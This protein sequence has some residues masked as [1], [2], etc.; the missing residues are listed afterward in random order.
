MTQ[1]IP[2]PP[3]EAVES[4]SP[5]LRHAVCVV[6]DGLLGAP[7]QE[8]R[9][10]P[11]AGAIYPYDVLVLVRAGEPALYWMDLLRRICVRLDAPAAQLAGL[12]EPARLPDASPAEA[13]IILLGRPW[14]SMRKYG[15][16]GYFYTQL[17]AGHAAASLLGTALEDGPAALRLRA[18]RSDIRTCLSPWLPHREVHSVLTIGAPHDRGEGVA[19][20]TYRLN[21]DAGL[22]HAD[23][24]ESLCWSG[25]PEVLYDNTL[26]LVEPTLI[27]SAPPLAGAA[28]ADSR[29]INVRRWREV[30][31]Q[32]RSCKKFSGGVPEPAAL[33]D[34][35]AALDTELPTDLSEAE[36]DVRLTLMTHDAATAEQC[37]DALR[38]SRIRVA[39]PD[40]FRDAGLLSR[41][42]IG[43][44]NAGR[45]A[46]FALFHTPGAQLTAAPR[47]STTRSSGRRRARICCTSARRAARWPSPRSGATTARSGGGSPGSR[48]PMKSSTCSRSASTRAAP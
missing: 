18:P 29:G 26:P 2:G 48:R 15:S 13:Q 35:L 9:Q 8:S 22:S 16:R 30:A 44:E 12:M 5:A 4:H 3:L 11:S 27:R 41:S 25:L 40:G 39:V 1:L 42:C 34:A 28:G 6:T 46:A 33:L 36:P 31:R 21:G 17:D 23:G 47:Q 24:L 43:Q 32:R 14:L 19:W 7:A 20:A 45:A 37:S 38:G 10:V